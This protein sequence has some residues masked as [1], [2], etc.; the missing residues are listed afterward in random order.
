M[1]WIALGW[2]A[3]LLAVF[4]A[5][6]KYGGRLW[7]KELVEERKLSSTLLADRDEARAT[8]SKIKGAAA[9]AQLDVKK[10]FPFLALIM[11]LV[12]GG[13]CR[14]LQAEAHYRHHGPAVLNDANATPGAADAE[15][16]KA[17]LCDP[18]FHTGTARDVTESQKRR[19]CAEYGIVRGCP[20]SGY[21]ID[22]LISIEL[23]G[24]NAD[25]NLWPQPAD[26]AGSGLV[27][28][29]TKDVVENRAHRAVCDGRLSL[30]AAQK[31][32]AADWYGFALANG[33]LNK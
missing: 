12:L 20:G 14:S 31:G 15:L 24:S 33:F 19:I 7:A 27:G 29:H 1:A 16:T 5:G 2:I 30:A 11:A 8:I 13:G 17:K 18:A 4:W 23:G 26:D 22:H 3:S 28:F 21:E 25:E 32:I 10:L 9:Q 6:A